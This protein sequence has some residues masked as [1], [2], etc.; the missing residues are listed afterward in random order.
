MAGKE[1]ALISV[2]PDPHKRFVTW[3]MYKALKT[4]KEKLK[5]K[6]KDDVSDEEYASAVED[7]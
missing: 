6:G 4:R 7:A 1:L 3:E 5:L 2:W